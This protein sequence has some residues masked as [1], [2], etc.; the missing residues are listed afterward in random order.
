MPRAGCMLHWS[1][2]STCAHACARMRGRGAPNT[3]E[4]GPDPWGV[5]GVNE[6]TS[7]AGCMMQPNQFDRNYARPPHASDLDP[8]VD[9]QPTHRLSSRPPANG[10]PKFADVACACA[11]EFVHLHRTLSRNNRRSYSYGWGLV[12]GA[13]LCAG[14]AISRR[15]PI[16]GL[17]GCSR[18]FPGPRF[19]PPRFAP[20]FHN[21][22]FPLTGV[23]YPR[24]SP[25][26]PWFSTPC[27]TP[28]SACASSVYDNV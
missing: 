4:R 10:A 22:L 23:L 1:H 24:L 8:P 5:A 16:P 19:W 2:G 7:C 21:D 20:G 28:E 12:P 9:A 14:P 13:Q 6:A 27:T 18:F 3:L 17:P 25:L 26:F 11:Q 15:R